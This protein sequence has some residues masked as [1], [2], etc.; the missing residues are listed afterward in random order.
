M[1]VT[2][3]CSPALTEAVT[4]QVSE[5]MREKYPRWT[6]HIK[7]ERLKRK[8]EGDR[9]NGRPQKI[10]RISC[11]PVLEGEKDVDKES[12]ALLLRNS[13]DWL[14]LPD[15][16]FNQIMMMIALVSPQT[17][18]RCTQVCSS[19]KS[20]ITKDILENKTKKNIIRTKIEKTMSP[21]M[22]PSSEEICNAMWLS[23]YDFLLS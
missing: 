21:G 8:M 22:F 14:N 19:W 4:K 17:L 20:K 3:K 2:I 1:S 11:Q 23:K 18:A 10:I 16:A 5:V 13:V 6:P 9:V 15:I 7:T 12:D